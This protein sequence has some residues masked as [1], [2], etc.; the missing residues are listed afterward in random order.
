MTIKRVTSAFLFENGVLA[1]FDEAGQ[2]IGELQGL[3]SIEKH[4]RIMAEATDNIELKGF[5]IL[6]AGFKRVVD[7]MTT[8]LRQNDISWQ[9]LR[10]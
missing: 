5:E 8:Y 4:Q 10:G 2:Q 7:Q 6:P 1:V 3:Y 9:E